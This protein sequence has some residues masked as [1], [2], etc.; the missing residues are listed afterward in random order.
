[1]SWQLQL[2]SPQSTLRHDGLHFSCEKDHLQSSSDGSEQSASERKAFGT[3]W[4]WTL[5]GVAKVMPD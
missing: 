5:A 3:G 1:M 2:M 4:R